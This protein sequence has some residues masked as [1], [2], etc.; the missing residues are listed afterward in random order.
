[1]GIRPSHSVAV[2][3]AGRPR[4]SV[5]ERHPPAR[6]RS[7][8][9]GALLLSLATVSGAAAQHSAFLLDAVGAD[10]VAPMTGTGSPLEADFAIAQLRNPRVLKA[11]MDAR[12]TVK[13]L[14]HDA[15]I[16]YPAAEIYL[17]AFKRERSLEL[18]ARPQGS[19][20]FTL[21]KTYDVCAISGDLGPKRRQGDE[22]VPE[23][24]YSI[25][26]FNP[27]SEYNLSLHVDYPNDVDRRRP[28]RGG[29]LGGDIYVHGG[30]ESIGCLAMTDQG[31]REL[32][33]ISVEARAAGQTRIPIHIFPG[34]LDD[35]GLARLT[36]MHTEPQLARFWANLKLGHDYFE[37]T[38]QL[39]EVLSGA[40]GLYRFTGLADAEEPPQDA[41]AHTR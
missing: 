23:G 22:Q 36:A 1:M 35:A 38:H 14:F 39:P 16:P 6:L 2:I 12:F 21:L 20:T 15:R 8:L 40:D 19:D 24:F 13:R 37:R 7:A 41:A 32:Y 10:L 9:T 26:L 31:I 18:W 4:S 29:S 11:R 28:G 3:A 30:C 17:R 33:W 25:D 27:Q 5:H 34:R